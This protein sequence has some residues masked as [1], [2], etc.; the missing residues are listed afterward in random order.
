MSNKGNSGQFLAG[1]IV[2]AL[3]GALAGVLLSPRSGTELREQVRENGPAALNLLLDD[4]QARIEAGRVAFR[5]SRAETRERMEQELRDSRHGGPS[6]R[7]DEP[8]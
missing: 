4:L 8:R 2:G 5:Q 1:L 6:I 3:S 7:P